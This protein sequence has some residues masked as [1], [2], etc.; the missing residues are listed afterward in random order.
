[1]VALVR[2]Q[3]QSGAIEDSYECRVNLD[4]FALERDTYPWLGHCEPYGDTVF[5]RLQMAS[6]VLEIDRVVAAEAP[7]GDLAEWLVR[8]RGMALRGS[9]QFHRYLWLFS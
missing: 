9:N 3:T 5:N 8:V 1:M 7:E 6:L 4:R 2:L